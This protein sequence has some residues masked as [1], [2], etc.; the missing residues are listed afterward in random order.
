MNRHAKSMTDQQLDE[1]LDQANQR[2]WTGPDH[3]PQFGHYLK[4]LTMKS[5]RTRI[6]SHS[7]LILLGVGALAGGSIAATVTHS[8]MSQRAVLTTEDGTQYHVELSDSPEGASGSFVTDDGTVY[9]VD[10]V[11]DGEQQ[12]VTLDVDS[13]NGGTTTMTFESDVDTSSST[14]PGQT[15]SFEIDPSNEDESS[16][17]DD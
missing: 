16:D 10:M 7:A 6:L 14:D 8:I 4:G 15:A 12:H 17:S 5:Q 13:S 2:E 11:E 1:L 9:G 3:S